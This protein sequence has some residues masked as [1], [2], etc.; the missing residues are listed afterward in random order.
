MHTVYF[1]KHRPGDNLIRCGF[2]DEVKRNEIING[3]Q[4][5]TRGYPSN[6][7]DLKDT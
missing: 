4:T 5:T 2:K 7:S 3:L 6:S 1:Y